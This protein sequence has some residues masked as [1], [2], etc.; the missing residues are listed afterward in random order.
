MMDLIAVSWSGGKDSALA[1]YYSLLEKKF[2]VHSLLTTISAE[3]NRTS[4]HGIRIE[5]LE[6]QIQSI[7]IPINLISL[8]KDVSNDEYEEIMK[9]EMI[10]LKSHQVLSVMFG[11]IFLEDLREYRK[12]NLAKIGMNALFPLWGKN[13]IE[14]AREFID[15]G[16]KAIITCVDSTY[17]ND[18]YVG[19][20]YDDNFLST[21]PSNI[22][23]CGENG[24]FHTFVFD[25]PIFSY[26][27]KFKKGEIVFREERFYFIDLVPQ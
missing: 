19:Q 2:E 1:L 15:L 16:F 18:S 20:I 8:P 17:L 11:D 23:P 27:I 26:P 5:L 3:Y 10:T 24:E 12:S 25:G 7:G 22:D 4:M 9:K 21:L 13:S 6:K 14:L